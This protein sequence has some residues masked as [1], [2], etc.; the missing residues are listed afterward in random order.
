[1]N[2]SSDKVDDVQTKL[3]TIEKNLPMMIQEI[4]DS[5]FDKKVSDLLSTI[6]TREEFRDAQKLKLD[7]C[8]FRDYE[9]MIA[10]DRT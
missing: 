8:I 5:Y 6:V 4:L 10:S 3:I 9:K 1:M 2:E 7:Y